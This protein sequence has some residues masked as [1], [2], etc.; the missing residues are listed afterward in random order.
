M[1]MMNALEHSLR[2]AI[3]CKALGNP[4]RLVIVRYLTGRTA[5]CPCGEIVRHLPLAQSTV[6]RHLKVLQAAGW[7][8]PT[9][10]PGVAGY[11]ID[12]DVVE[13]FRRLAAAL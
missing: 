7:I 9:P 8:R 2:L 12:P 11:R 1:A 10:R 13:D 3:L 6:S 5:G 4:A